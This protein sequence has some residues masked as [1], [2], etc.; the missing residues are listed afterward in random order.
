MR[1]ILIS[2][3]IPV[4]LIMLAV[5]AILG[6]L[7][8]ENYI[9]QP[10]KNLKTAQRAAVHLGY[11]NEDGITPHFDP[12]F[13]A[14][15]SFTRV[16]IP[17]ADRFDSPMGTEQGGFIYNAQGFNA[18]N[19][20][21]GGYHLGDDLNGIGGQNSDEDDPVYSAADGLVVYSGIPSPGWGRVTVVAHKL[22]DGRIVQTLYAHLKSTTAVVGN[23]IARGDKIGTIGTAGGRYYAHLH[24][25]LRESGG[26]V[27]G[28]G[29]NSTE[30]TSGELMDPT[31]FAKQYNTLEATD[32]R[33]SVLG[34]LLRNERKALAQEL[35]Q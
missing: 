12:A 6:Q 23:L 31:A 22:H 35:M 27:I 3:G 13:D 2:V 33:P 34:I 5:W 21:R 18:P 14:L 25:E 16:Q 30:V 19:Q 20:A 8:L 17:I 1:K 7:K 10:V 11:P 9:T 32:L 15:S 24:Y 29:Y 28:G 4:L 26:V